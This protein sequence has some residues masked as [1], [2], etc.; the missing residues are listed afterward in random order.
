MSDASYLDSMIEP[1]GLSEVQFETLLLHHRVM[2]R[3]ITAAEAARLRTPKP[4]SLGA[5][6]RVLEQGRANLREALVTI[7]VGTKLQ[8]IK[9]DE[10]DRLLKIVRESPGFVVPEQAD[11]FLAL[12]LALVK[13]IVM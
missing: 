10:F 1:S 11:A 8:W 6:Y 4:V 3:E 7:I 2:S 13:K 12:V 5:Y 9:T